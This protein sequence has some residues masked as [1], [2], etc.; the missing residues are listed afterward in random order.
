MSSNK[1]GLVDFCLK[2]DKKICDQIGKFVYDHI[3]GIFP[4]VVVFD[5]SSFINEQ[6]FT[7]SIGTIFMISS[8]GSYN[9]KYKSFDLYTINGTLASYTDGFPWIYVNNMYKKLNQ[10]LNQKL[11]L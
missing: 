1:K 2:L 9:C 8:G 6:G 3:K 7:P 4:D 5:E 10:K 11:N